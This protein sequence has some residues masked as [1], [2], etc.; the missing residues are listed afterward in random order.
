MIL[1]TKNQFQQCLS[2]SE[3]GEFVAQFKDLLLSSVFQPIY[4]KFNDV[5]GVEALI[6]IF[7]N[8]S[9]TS[10]RPDQF[11]HSSLTPLDD[12]INVE[13]LSRVIHIRNFAISSFANTSLFLNILPAAGE[14]FALSDVETCLLSS[15]LKELQI[16]RSQLVMELLEI[17]ENNTFQFKTAIQKLSDAGYQI[18]IDD[19]GVSASTEQ[20]V[21][22]LQPNIIKIDRSL[23]VKYVSGDTSPLLNGVKIAND[24]NAKVVVE[25]IETEEQFHAMK[26]LNIDMYQGYYLAMPSPITPTLKCTG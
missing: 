15:R 12:K 9:K 8:R 17:E 7:N 23:L 13:R 3:N 5:V 16:D 20:R 1:S 21:K 26:S 2:T 10:I 22:L 14:S 18:A 25:G 11:F 19:F 6:R 4:N 24:I